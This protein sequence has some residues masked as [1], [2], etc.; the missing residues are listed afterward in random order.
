MGQDK[1]RGAST[2]SHEAHTKSKT[3]KAPLHNYDTQGNLA[4]KAKTK[5]TGKEKGIINKKTV[6]V[7]KANRFAS[8]FGI[9]FTLII[10]TTIFIVLKYLIN[11]ISLTALSLQKTKEI[12]KLTTQL[13]VMTQENNILEENINNGIDYDYMYDVAIDELGMIYPHKSQIIYYNKS[14]GLY[15]VEQYKTIDKS[16]EH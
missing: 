12:T 14:N 4:L 3:K 5:N 13:A 7:Q 8:S 9:G 1:T 2:V 6:T 11:Y 15:Y 16:G 10:C